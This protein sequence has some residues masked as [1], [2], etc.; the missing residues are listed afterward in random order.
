MWLKRSDYDRLVSEA[1]TERAKRE[2]SIARI[3]HLESSFTWLTKH[4]NTLALQNGELL[5]RITGL[6]TPVAQIER[7]PVAPPGSFGGDGPN[8]ALH[9]DMG[10]EAAK[11]EGLDVYGEP[12]VARE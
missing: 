3:A 12:G 6:P 5:H 9:E 2:T 7:G 8:V 10:D 11:R 4:V 1:A